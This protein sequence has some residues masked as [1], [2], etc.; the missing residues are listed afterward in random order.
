[1]KK[2]F[3]PMSAWCCAAMAVSGLTVAPALGAA[4]RGSAARIVHAIAPDYPQS[5]ERAHANGTVRVQVALNAAGRVSSARISRSSGNAALDRSAL[6]AARD[7]TY[8]AARKGCRS[9]SGTYA[10]RA[11]F[12]AKP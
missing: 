10:F 1:M 6:L 12:D 5:A 9:I 8:V 7:S 2:L 4:C 11:T 3:L